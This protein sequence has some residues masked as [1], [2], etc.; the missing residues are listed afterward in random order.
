MKRPFLLIPLTAAVVCGVLFLSWRMV[1]MR[2]SARVPDDPPA[3]ASAMAT[4]PVAV[5]R[6]PSGDAVVQLSAASQHA[7]GLVAK[8]ARAATLRPFVRAWGRLQ[9]DPADAT[10]IAAPRG[11]TLVGAGRWPH[12]GDDIAAGTVLGSVTPVLRYAD[13]LSQVTQSSDLAARGALARASVAQVSASLATARSQMQGARDT[14]RTDRAELGRLRHLN[15]S[16]KIASDRAVMAADLRVRLDRSRVDLARQQLRAQQQAMS[17][18]QS[19]LGLLE[20]GS[21]L[22]GPSSS[23]VP[24]LSPGA[25]RVVA[26]YARPGEAVTAGQVLLRVQRYDSLQ[27][28]L[29]LSPSEGLSSP[30]PRA[31]VRLQAGD[32]PRTGRA[33]ASVAL[34]TGGLRGAYRAHLVAAVDGDPVS[35]AQRLLYRVDATGTV[36]RPGMAVTARL[37]VA[38]AGTRAVFVPEG[39]I[40]REA[41]RTSVYVRTDAG[42]FTRRDVRLLSASANG[43]LVSGLLPGTPVVSVGAQALLSAELQGVF[44]APPASAG[45]SGGDGDDD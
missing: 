31:R 44:T 14:L 6:L 22:P 41:S 7:L 19:A 5:L 25:G 9:A 40:V 15:A 16:G 38:G 36:L 43:W 35:G 23:A 11:G 21:R 28:L 20:N 8:P 42:S 2:E 33:D 45:N 18:T 17:A 26:V 13:R 34:A 1:A 30:P 4:P 29:T 24:L 3:A 39:A 27:V 10:V 37:A 12:V 32:V